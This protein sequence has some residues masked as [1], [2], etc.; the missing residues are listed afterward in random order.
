METTRTAHRTGGFRLLRYFS[1]ASLIA[2]VLA[3]VGL[4]YFFRQTALEQVIKAGEDHNVVLSR[5][6]ANSL[7]QHY[8][9]LIFAAEKLTTAQLKLNPAV[10]AVHDAVLDAVRQTNVVKVKIFDLKGR[11]LY[12]SEARQIGEDRG[13]RPGFQAARAGGVKTVLY[14]RQSIDAFGKTITDRDLLGSY[15]PARDAASGAL[16]AVFELY[17]D[18][19]PFFEDLRRTQWNLRIGVGVVLV[20][21]YATLFAIVKRADEVISSQAAQR[22]ED[23]ETIRHLAHHDPLTG[24]PNR[25]LFIDRLS[26]ALAR[27]RR[28]GRLAA[29]MYVD[30]DR[31]KEINDTR[32]HAVGDKVLQVAGK[33]L[34][35]LL[36]DAD[37]VARLGG[38]EFTIVLDDIADARHAGTVAAKIREAFADPVVTGDGADIVVTP[39]TGIALYPADADDVDALIHAADAAMY[40]AKAAG[41]N[42]Y[43]FYR[44]PPRARASS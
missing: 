40:D 13:A 11:T 16:D 4:G 37:T 33:R 10:S 44:P 5:A 21:L 12:S 31:F 1:I 30:F 2:I 29:L 41:R 22:A 27:A 36:R 38:D 17:T 15:V 32:G 43:R 18:V 7:R 9:P 35:G 26:L 34:R 24:L 3:L 8:I 39:S 20:L 23:E 28:N 14:E 6:L 19:T 42:A 25:K